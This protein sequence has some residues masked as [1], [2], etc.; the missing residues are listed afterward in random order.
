MMMMIIITVIF[1]IILIIIINI[2]IILSR[3]SLKSYSG[4][5]VSKNRRGNTL[6]SEKKKIM[7]KFNER[8]RE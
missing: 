7:K 2:I 8:N 1:T 3:H 4:L 6:I 5:V